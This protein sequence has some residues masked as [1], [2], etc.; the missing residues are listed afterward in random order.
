MKY[1]RWTLLTLLALVCAGAATLFI[2]DTSDFSTST[3][4]HRVRIDPSLGPGGFGFGVGRG[5]RVVGGALSEN[6]GSLQNVVVVAC[7]T[8]LCNS[9]AHSVGEHA[10][11]FDLRFDR[12]RSS[13][14]GVAELL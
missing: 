3:I 7:T 4:Q 2:I 11:L 10:D 8:R 1:V 13:S 12:C 6:Q 5:N 9:A 14:P